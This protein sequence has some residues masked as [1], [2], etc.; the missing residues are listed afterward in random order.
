L[1]LVVDSSPRFGTVVGHS[2]GYPGFGSHMRWHPA[3]GLGVVVLANGTYAPAFVLTERILDVLLASELDGAPGAAVRAPV[4]EGGRPWAAT[5]VAA[6][7]VERL[8]AAWDDD[9]AARLFAENVD[10]DEPLAVRRARLEQ[11]RE[12]LGP[13]EPDPAAGVEHASPAHRSW[14]MRGPGGRLRLDLRMTPQRPPL[15]Q[16][17]ALVPVPEPSP[18]LRRAVTVLRWS[19]NSTH[20]AVP[21]LLAFTENVD[22][23]ALQRLLQAG[24]AWAGAVTIG[25]VVGGDGFND[26]LIRLHG[27]RRD[28]LVGV[29]LATSQ[30]P[31]PG[32]APRVSA[33][34]LR[35]APD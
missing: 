2:G 30:P 16:S 9:L 8:V 26:T 15:V 18:D 19:L 11:L 28:L 24:A 31:G 20:A 35:P 4:P 12:L 22:R 1:G 27:T 5:E 29:R 23:G 34:S 6:A 21:P 14:W 25:N 32:G 33:V 10:L 17:L 13:F 3:T 7:D